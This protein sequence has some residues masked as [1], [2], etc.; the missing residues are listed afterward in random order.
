MLRFTMTRA[1]QSVPTLFI[2]SGVVF[3][4]A[5]LAPGDPVVLKLGSQALAPGNEQ[6]VE[7]MRSELGLDQPLVTQFLLW[8]RDLA[9]GD[10]GVS[11]HSGQSV[12]R[13]LLDRLP[14]TVQLMAA[15]ML[16]ALVVGIPLG[17]LAGARP[18]SWIDRGVTQLTA[19]GLAVPM[20]WMALILIL[21]VAVQWQ[22]LPPSGY[23][24]L[25]EDPLE[26]IKRTILP[27]TALA[28]REGA[29]FAKFVRA[30]MRETLAQDYIR[31][32]RAKG[33]GSFGVVRHHALKSTMI[34]LIT[35]IGVEVGVLM[36]GVVV[37]EQVFGWSGVG[38]QAVQALLNRDYAVV[39]GVVLMTGMVYVLVNLLVD[40]LYGLLDPRARAW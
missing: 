22:I 9:H 24:P 37:V 27:A 20:F 8:L 21:V 18:D 11:I 29:I 10:L 35:V 1:W 32:A 23:V 12:G 38:W 31:V 6:I 15:T 2:V 26:S 4:L 39:A 17:V 34:P 19:L 25:I 30:E 3:I 5:R 16:L 28:V 13:I 14:A 36:G 40:L 7:R 33:L